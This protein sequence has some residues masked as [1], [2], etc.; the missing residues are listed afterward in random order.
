MIWWHITKTWTKGKS[1]ESLA[2]IFWL[3]KQDGYK[4]LTSSCAMCIQ[5]YGTANMPVAYRRNNFCPILLH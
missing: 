4:L 5:T 3:V 2:Q 1:S